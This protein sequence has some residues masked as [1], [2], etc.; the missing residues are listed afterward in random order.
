MERRSWP[1]VILIVLGVIFLAGQQLEIGGE[2]IVAAIGLAFL[3]AYVFTHHYGLLVPGGIMTGLGLGIVFE[4]NI[5]GQGAP[6]LLGLGLGFL[7]I[8]VID[9]AGRRAVWGWWPL[10]PGGVLTLVGLLQ[11]GSQTGW[12][13]V[14]GR[15]WP[16]ALIGAGVYLLLRRPG[17]GGAPS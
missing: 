9:T 4:T 2:G 14:V 16:A 8:Y 5:G 11:A 1:G 6:V 17:D 13:G 7:T 3:V 10:V 12:L 15:W